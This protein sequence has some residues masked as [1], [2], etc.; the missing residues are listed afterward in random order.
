MG[1]GTGASQYTDYSNCTRG[2]KQ[3][4]VCSPVLFLLCIN[5]LA[6]EII[7]AGRHDASFRSSL[8]ELFVLL[9]ADDILLLSETVVGLQT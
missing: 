3:G 5:D 1:A 6:L 2:V 8:V 9:F 4:G 7:I